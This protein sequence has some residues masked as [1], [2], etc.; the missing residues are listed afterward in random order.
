MTFCR[1]PGPVGRATGWLRIH[2]MLPNGRPQNQ[3]GLWSRRP[4]YD[5]Q[6]ALRNSRFSKAF[7]QHH[8]VSVVLKLVG[9]AVEKSHEAGREWKR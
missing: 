6:L 3:H 4:D 7:A 2:R 5:A 9:H 1:P 8:H